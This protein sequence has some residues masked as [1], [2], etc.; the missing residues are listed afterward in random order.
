MVIRPLLNHLMF[1]FELFLLS[2][3][4]LHLHV[5]T[6]LASL[7]VRRLFGCLALCSSSICSF[8]A[9]TS[10]FV[11]AELIKTLQIN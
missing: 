7:G 8:F 1:S 10:Y 9:G 3:G 11:A 2:V 6:F 4:V 5:D